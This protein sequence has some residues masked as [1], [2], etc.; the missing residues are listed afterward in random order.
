MYYVYGINGIESSSGLGPSEPIGRANGPAIE[1][2]AMVTCMRP[3][4]PHIL[5]SQSKFSD[6]RSTDVDKFSELPKLP[7]NG[8][9]TDIS[10]NRKSTHNA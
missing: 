8:E 4:C 9:S 6:R 1:H 3:L 5:P 7:R 10:T 2:I